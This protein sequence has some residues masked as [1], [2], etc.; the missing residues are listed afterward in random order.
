MSLLEERAGEGNTDVK[1]K[2]ETWCLY[3]KNNSQ[4]S[5]QKLQKDF[6]ETSFRHS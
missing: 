6:M 4:L 5:S 1:D 2:R 3:L